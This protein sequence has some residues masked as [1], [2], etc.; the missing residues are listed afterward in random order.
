MILGYYGYGNLGDEATLRGMIGLLRRAGFGRI[1]VLSRDPRATA[2]REGVKAVF[3]Y[4]PLRILWAIARSDLFLFGGG[5]LLQ[6]K[7]S[8]R[9]LLYYDFIS[10][11]A[12][13]AGTDQ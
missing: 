3:R 8:K 5:T 13:A 2:R 1:T 10:R 7:T 6:D 12:K 9:S 4:A 11:L